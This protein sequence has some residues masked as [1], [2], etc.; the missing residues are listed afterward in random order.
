VK[1][2]LKPL[3]AVGAEEG[4]FS[5]AVKGAYWN[6]GLAVANKIFTLLGQVALAWLLSPADM[7]LAGM[8]M[9]MAGFT[10]FLS[11]GGLSDVLVQ[12]DRYEQEAGQGLWL[13][14]MMYSFMALLIALLVPVSLWTGRG[15]LA[16]LLLI[17][18]FS[19]LISGLDPVLTARLKG[20]LDFKNLAI[21]Q[22]LQG[23]TYTGLALIFAWMGW[24]PYAL[25]LPS[26]LRVMVGTGF[27]FWRVGRLPWEPLRLG[28]IKKLFKPTAALALTG[29][30]IGLQ[31]QAPVFCAGLVLNPTGTGH[32]AWGWA[33]ASQT[34]FLL[35]INLRQVLMPIFVKIGDDTERQRTS[36]F[37][38]ARI[39]TAALTLVCGLQALLAEPLLDVFFPAKW[40]PAGPVIT[41]V[42]LGLVLQGV[43]VSISSWLNAVGR[44]RDLLLVSV[45]PALLAG[46]LAYLGA[47]I[48]G[49]EGAAEG[50]AVGSL[51]GAAFSFSQMAWIGFRRQIA[52]LLISFFGVSLVWLV[53][54]FLISKQ[55]GFISLGL[56]STVFLLA[57]GSIWWF[58]DDGMIKK[59]F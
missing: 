36:V 31:T 26:I 45:V 22:F 53:C 40:H 34:V 15:E 42:S 9:A 52:K 58:S 4:L 49:A 1:V 38:S 11:A 25:V 50:S 21:S 18:A 56:F 57:G 33:I 37:Q 41:W 44:Y 19:N 59:C 30:F 17:I 54:H 24:G 29:F 8:A 51:L 48:N 43:W 3:P 39:M 46:G 7:G 55:D 13:S 2:R 23:I 35:A 5:V 10:A 32:F 16:G 14:M 27:D 6:V 47:K 12:R 20:R 28:F